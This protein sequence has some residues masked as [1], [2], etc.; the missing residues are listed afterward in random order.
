MSQYMNFDIDVREGQIDGTKSANARVKDKLLFDPSTAKRMEFRI[1]DALPNDI[2]AMLGRQPNE[3]QTHSYAVIRYT[4]GKERPVR[5]FGQAEKF[6]RGSAQEAFFAEQPRYY[7]IVCKLT[8]DAQQKTW[9]IYDELFN[10][11]RRLSVNGL[12][13]AD[14][15]YSHDANYCEEYAKYISDVNT[16]RPNLPWLLTEHGTYRTV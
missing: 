8:S 2:A 1:V 5:E 10:S 4:V 7:T 11:V 12:P 6:T 9:Q 15:F 3:P 14:W 16:P 13:T